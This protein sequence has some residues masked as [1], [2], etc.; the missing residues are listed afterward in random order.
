M[1]I[2]TEHER[3]AAGVDYPAAPR[4]YVPPF[5]H[6]T[7]Y[8]WIRRYRGAPCIPLWWNATW[9]RNRAEGWG[10]YSE[11]DREHEWEYCGPCPSPDDPA[12]ALLPNG[13]QEDGKS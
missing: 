2:L 13:L 4:R 12:P 5:P 8:H 11:P 1:T 9:H 10:S 6:L 7:R 3:I